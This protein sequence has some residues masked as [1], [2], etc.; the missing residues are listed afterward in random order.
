MRLKLNAVSRGLP[1]AKLLNSTITAKG[2]SFYDFTVIYNDADGINRKSINTGDLLVTGP[3]GFTQ[4]A[5]RIGV[6]LKKRG[7][8]AIAT[9]RI[10]AP[11]N[12]WDLGDN[13]T[14][15]VSLQRR[16]V[17]DK[18]GNFAKRARLN[19]GIQVAIPNEPPTARL[20]SG[21]VSIGTYTFTVT[22][23]DE[24]AINVASIDSN[25]LQVTGPNGFNQPAQLLAINPASNTTPLTATYQITAP[26]GAWF[27]DND[28][29]Y[30]VSLKPNQVT[31]TFGAAVA[32]TAL[33]PFVIDS[34]KIPPIATLAAAN[35]NN[36]GGSTY[37]FTVTYIDNEAVAAA[38]LGT[39]DVR[40]TGPNG[41]NQIAT[42]VGTSSSTNGTPRTATYRINAPGGRWDGPDAGLYTV[43]VEPNQVSDTRNNFVTPGGIGTFAV[44]IEQTAPVAT[45][46]SA[47]QIRNG[48]RSALLTVNYADNTAIDFSTLD[49][50]EVRVLGPN[51]YNQLARPVRIEPNGNSPSV[52][53]TYEIDAPDNA[54]GSNPQASGIY[55]VLLDANQVGDVNGNVTGVINLGTFQVQ[56]SPFRL[57]AET[58]ALSNYIVEGSA[59]ASNQQLIGLNATSTSAVTGTATATFPG[60]TGIYDLVIRYVDENDGIGAIQVRVDGNLVGQWNL[61]KNLGS[62]TI[63]PQAFT[64][65]TLSGIAIN[66]NSQ[67]QIVGIQRGTG[68][69]SGEAVRIDYIDF[70]PRLNG[71]GVASSVG[72]IVSTTGDNAV[73]ASNGIT[74]VDYSQL[75]KGIIADLS[76]GLVLKPS[77][78]TDLTIPKIMP[79]GDSLTSGEHNEQP[80]T[81][82][83]YRIQLYKKFTDDGLNLNFVGTTNQTAAPNTLPDKD[84]Q[85]S[86]GKLSDTLAL[87]NSPDFTTYIAN[88][89]NTPNVVLLMIGTVDTSNSNGNNSPLQTMQADLTALLSTGAPDPADP[90]KRLK[91][92]TELLPNTQI[93]VASVPPV[94]SPPNTTDRAKRITDYNDL[95]P[96][97]VGAAAAA[98]KN[99]QFVDINAALTADDLLPTS[100][101]NLKAS[102]DTKIGDAW[103]NALIDRDTLTGIQNIVGTGLNDTLTGNNGNNLIAGGLGSDRLTGGSG[104]D[105]F[106][107]TSPN[108]GG[109]TIT[110]FGPSD[111]IQISAAGFGGGLV[112]NTALSNGTAS[113]TGVYVIGNTPV[114]TSAN[115]LYSSGV[116]KFDPDGIGPAAAIVI[117]TLT[118]APALNANQFKIVT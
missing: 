87:I 83:G 14:Y 91:S 86:P 50:R 53:V 90:T 77:Y 41:F 62:S 95:I 7:I 111:L 72:A 84:Y 56:L 55:T 13:G 45:L 108:E 71:P 20:G 99:V 38:S 57:E 67:I 105:T 85:A 35:I 4:V 47:P 24:T 21:T 18:K 26:A 8:Q 49:G 97:I 89:A 100:G 112:V 1:R 17:S 32:A 27:A 68:A 82:G 28:G 22:Y 107:Y 58:M 70:I 12:S 117:A 63:A 19:G 64:Q 80:E 69:Q 29:T 81:P 113:P 78:G 54:W 34:S 116:L 48:S 37:D 106:S 79:L 36:T 9:Y 94:A 10:I 92:V 96:G 42:L 93:L 115:F 110:D 75:N 59:D 25:D 39:G 16:Q 101:V 40:V 3:N 104:T 118:G 30:V 102:G 6:K 66:T 15:S 74:T 46:V 43:S 44:T 103:Y 73:T 98:G 33:G 60:A 65:R 51:G 76:K 114:G 109:D 31:D 61:D 23:A 88:P 52:T 11:G 2:S 5:Q